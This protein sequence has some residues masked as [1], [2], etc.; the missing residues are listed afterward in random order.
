MSQAMNTR[1]RLGAAL[2]GGTRAVAAMRLGLGLG[3]A[4]VVGSGCHREPRTEQAPSLKTIP[5]QVG[6]VASGK[7]RAS[8]DVMGSVRSRKRAVI[9][10]KVSG[11]IEAMRV[12]PGRSVAV[13]EVLAELEVGEIRAKVDQAKAVALQSERDFERMSALFK[14]EAVTRA[15]LDA[16]EARR[17]VARAALGEAEAMQ[18]YARIVAPFEGVVT[19]KLAD[20]GD[21]AVPGK[22]LLEIEDPKALRFEADVPGTLVEWVRPGQEIPVSIAAG[23]GPTTGIVSE[24]EP[25]ADPVSRTFRVRLD[26]PAE[27]EARGGW[28]GRMTLPLQ[29]VAVT[30][31][32]TQAVTQRGQ[33]EYVWVVTEGKARLRIVKTGKRLGSDFE[34][35]SGLDSGETVVVSAE[36]ELADGQPVV[37]R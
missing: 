26:L 17:G 35:L 12:V 15:E 2:R 23:S 10:A 7:R 31:V 22:P 20:V 8:E 28:F 32:A 3:L 25:S 4:V 27:T 29:E 13:G 24:V 11:R 9:E 37:K 1:G 18:A 34:V 19:R 14:Q 6:T 5:V 30:T 36:G 16:V 33:M 21:L